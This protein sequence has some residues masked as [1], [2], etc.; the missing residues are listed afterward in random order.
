MPSQA[1]EGATVKEIVELRSKNLGLDLRDHESKRAAEFKNHYDAELDAF[2]RT[3]LAAA[4]ERLATLGALAPMLVVNCS[5]RTTDSLMYFNV[6]HAIF[7]LCHEDRPVTAPCEHSLRSFFEAIGLD[8]RVLHEIG[9]LP[10]RLSLSSG[11]FLIHTHEYQQWLRFGRD[12]HKPEP[13]S[14]CI[15]NIVVSRS[16]I[17]AACAALVDF[18]AAVANGDLTTAGANLTFR[19]CGVLN[20]VSRRFSK[21]P[22]DMIEMHRVLRNILTLKD[23]AVRAAKQKLVQ[24]E[25]ARHDSS[26]RVA[27]DLKS[28]HARFLKP[29]DRDT[30]KFLTNI[31]ADNAFRLSRPAFRKLVEA[32]VCIRLLRCCA[33][34]L[35]LVG[36]APEWLSHTGICASLISLVCHPAFEEKTNIDV[37]ARIFLLLVDIGLLGSSILRFA[38]QSAHIHPSTA[39]P[40]FVQA[41]V[42]ISERVI[43][44]VW[45][46][47][48]TSASFE[49]VARHTR[50]NALRENL[51][52]L[53]R[54]LPAKDRTRVPDAS[55]ADDDSIAK[56]LQ[57]VDPLVRRAL[58]QLPS[59]EGVLSMREAP[60]ESVRHAPVEKGAP[61]GALDLVPP[62]SSR[63]VASEVPLTTGSPEGSVRSAS[64]VPLRD[65]SAGKMPRRARSMSVYVS[66]APQ[67]G[68]SHGRA[69]P[70]DFIVRSGA[71]GRQR[72]ARAGGA[73][74]VP[75]DRS[76]SSPTQVPRAHGARSTM[77]HV[78]HARGA[79]S[80]SAESDES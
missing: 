69:G 5:S 9:S 68:S 74:Q 36:Q 67:A 78:P 77:R 59:L 38:V 31:A 47:K 70:R 21:H 53:I 73:S 72:D 32:E 57:I 2:D 58:N 29:V 26:R 6:M 80:T 46:T 12:D 1:S 42:D 39:T 25:H 22:L 23:D 20:A 71:R 79:R 17:G 63:G 34:S 19:L 28:D 14:S 65:R 56:E 52:H 33:C 75:R 51:E 15:Y 66:A 50:V 4:R 41:R 62:L 3:Q 55:Y 61:H 10:V 43:A 60:G 11:E 40:D 7:V 30:A 44:E 76:T 35:T 27:L 37:V 48:D 45:K 13:L 64:E 24:A 18:A 8:S 49:E 16:N 54:A